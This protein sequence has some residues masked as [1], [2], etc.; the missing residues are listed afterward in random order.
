MASSREAARRRGGRPDRAVRAG[1]QSRGRADAPGTRRAASTGSRRPAR[2]LAAGSVDPEQTMMFLD[3]AGYLPDNNLVKVDRASMSVGLEIR[4]PLLD[5][6]VVE[7]AFRLPLAMR[8]GQDR[9]KLVLWRLLE[10]YVPRALFERR[11]QGF[12]VPVGPWLR[13]PLRDWA[14][15]SARRAQAARGRAARRGRGRGGLGAAHGAGAQSIA[16]VV[17]PVDVSGLARVLADADARTSPSN[18]T[19]GGRGRLRCL[20]HVGIGWSQKRSVTKRGPSVLGS[21]QCR[22]NE[23]RCRPGRAGSLPDHIGGFRGA[24]T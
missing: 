16:A 21:K 11:K 12:G 20:G 18:G 2:L 1:A 4:S 15:G 19:G 24:E 10:R 5:H 23:P 9:G 17:A 6:R 7:L 8:L 22:V 14:E 13:G 3:L